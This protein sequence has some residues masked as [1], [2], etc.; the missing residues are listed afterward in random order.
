MKE[1]RFLKH[2]S[3]I[4]KYI[5]V[6]KKTHPDDPAAHFENLVGKKRKRTTPTRPRKKSRINEVVYPK[7]EEMCQKKVSRREAGKVRK[8]L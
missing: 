6:G 8:M 5:A 1:Y 3:Y 7:L 2:E 4:R